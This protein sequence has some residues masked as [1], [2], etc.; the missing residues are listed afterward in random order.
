MADIS[1][2]HRSCFA[3]VFCTSTGMITSPDLSFPDYPECDPVKLH[4]HHLEQTLRKAAKFFRVIG[5]ATMA[6]ECEQ[7]LQSLSAVTEP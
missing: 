1:R 7:A 5:S 3:R 6:R 4:V 2:L